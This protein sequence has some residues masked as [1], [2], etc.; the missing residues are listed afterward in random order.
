[1]GCA[2][3]I[4]FLLVDPYH[5]SLDILF[6]VIVGPSRRIRILHPKAHRVVA[7]IVQI[8]QR[9]L[10]ASAGIVSPLCH[11]QAV[12]DIVLRIPPVCVA[13]P[14]PQAVYIVLIA[15]GFSSQTVACQLAPVPP[16]HCPSVVVLRRV[17]V[18]VIRN[19]LPIKGRQQVL[20]VAVSVGIRMLFLS[21]RC[22]PILNPP[23][24]QV[25]S[26]VIIVLIPLLP[27]AISR[28]LC[29]ILQL[30]Q[31]V[32]CI[33]PVF[34]SIQVCFLDNI[35]P[36]IICISIPRQLRA[37][38]LRC[39]IVRLRQRGR[40][41]GFASRQVGVVFLQN[42]A[43]L[44]FVQPGQVIIVVIDPAVGKQCHGLQRAF[45]Y[46]GSVSYHL[47]S[48]PIIIEAFHPTVNHSRDGVAHPRQAVVGV[49][50][51]RRTQL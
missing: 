48:V 8:P 5:I 21:V 11:C 6:K 23:G 29:G 30:S 33:F 38:S 47:T 41:S 16:R 32:I 25:S 2:V 9:V 13:L 45:S 14:C 36:L 28:I 22:R 51:I 17:P 18:G 37:A 3:S 15:V 4:S 24:C 44:S 31:L 1:M 27:C 50:L 42:A 35:V 20:P 39:G 34:S 40:C 19:C 26:M 10:H 12:Y 7:L 46:I 49:V 43:H